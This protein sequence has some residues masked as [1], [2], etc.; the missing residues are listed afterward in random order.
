MNAALKVGG[1]L[2]LG[3]AWGLF[4]GAVGLSGAESFLGGMVLGAAYSF[5]V[6]L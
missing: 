3:T 1:L 2:V 4:A 5:L 6:P